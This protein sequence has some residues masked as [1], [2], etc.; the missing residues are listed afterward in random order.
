[1]EKIIFNCLKCGFCCRNLLKEV[2]GKTYGLALFPEEIQLFPKK[3][4]SPLCG[5]GDLLEPKY[6][7]NYQ[8]NVAECPHILTDNLCK[9]HEKRP[10]SCCS[11]PLISL[12]FHG[13]TVADAES[14]TFIE[15][16]EKKAGP[17]ELILTPE[18]FQAK[19][20]WEAIEKSN[21]RLVEIF[22]HYLPENHVLWFFDLKTKKWH[23]EK[24]LTI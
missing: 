12:G 19:E 11:F 6:I 7:V 20:E 13:T 9:I 23:I 24:I 21:E 22:T 18:K 4:T 1:M 8:L 10:L 2:S 5:L 16:V 14:C 3:L 15:K 17:L